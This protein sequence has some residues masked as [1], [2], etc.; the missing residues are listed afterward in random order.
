MAGLG[1]GTI[2]TINTLV[3]QFAVPK[4]MLGVAVGAIFFFVFLGSAIAPA[5]QGSAMNAAYAKALH[6]S[7]PAELRQVADDAVLESLTDSRVLLSPQ[8]M[9]GLRQTLAGL[10]SRGPALLEETVQ[11]I[12][13]ALEAGLK[14]VFVIGAVAMLISF[15]LILTIPEVS[16][17]VE[18]RDKTLRQ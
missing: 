9:E 10:G 13:S 3:V 8:A 15:L 2:P 4:R 12:R 16:M 7:L 18:V 6:G 17:D 5:I 1:L 11:A 14:T